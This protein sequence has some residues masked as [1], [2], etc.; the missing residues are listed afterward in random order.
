MKAMTKI[1][2]KQATMI[3][4]Q[5]SQNQ[6]EDLNT[7]IEN[8]R[9]DKT[10][11][12]KRKLDNV[13]EQ[14]KDTSKKKGTKQNKRKPIPKPMP[15]AKR[16]K[17]VPIS[18]VTVNDEIADDSST[19]SEI[20]CSYQH[21]DMIGSYKQETDGRYFKEGCELFE[22]KC[23]LISCKSLTWE[24]SKLFIEQKVNNHKKNSKN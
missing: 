15:K 17:I 23:V 11:K 21:S 7:A 1:W 3:D 9:N 10:S 18:K 4:K 5:L 19:E 2:Q 22:M 13:I 16:K 14:D 24:S 8:V 12:R 20:S 6:D